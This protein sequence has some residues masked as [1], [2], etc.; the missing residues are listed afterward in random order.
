M[1]DFYDWPD[2]NLVN[3]EKLNFK[4]I[5]T[6]SIFKIS[7]RFCYVSWITSEKQN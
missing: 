3:V 7:N 6:F 1:I 4:G 5:N 2:S